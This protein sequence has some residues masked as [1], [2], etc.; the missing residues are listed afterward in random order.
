MTRKELAQKAFEECCDPKNI[1]HRG[2]GGAGTYWNCSSRQFMYAPAFYFN[3]IGSCG[4][5]RYDVIC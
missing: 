4:K 3:G 5:Y 1:I 2:K